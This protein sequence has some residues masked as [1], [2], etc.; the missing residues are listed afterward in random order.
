MNTSSSEKPLQI[1]QKCDFLNDEIAS[2]DLK[3]INK[4]LCNHCLRTASNGVKC[5]GKC[6]AD[7]E[8]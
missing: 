7:N 6:V 4:I 8:Y 1:E 3:E 5:I 2:G